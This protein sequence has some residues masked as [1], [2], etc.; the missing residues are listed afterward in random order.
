[1]IGGSIITASS[2]IAD[3]LTVEKIRFLCDRVKLYLINNQCGPGAGSNPS[4][5]A[6]SI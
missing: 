5:S 4:A 1:M 3:G 6:A 2:K